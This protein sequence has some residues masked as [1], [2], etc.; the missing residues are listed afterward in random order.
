MNSSIVIPGCTIAQR[1]SGF[2]VRTLFIYFVKSI[3]IPWFT[4]CPARL[5]PP[6][7]GRNI[8]LLSEHMRIISA[9]SSAFFGSAIPNGSIW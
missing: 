7:R 4:V 9:T 2:T 8:V 3:T 5:V 1:S 6:P